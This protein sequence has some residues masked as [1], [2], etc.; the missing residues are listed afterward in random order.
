[1]TAR[2]RDLRGR[3]LAGKYVLAERIGSGATGIVFRAEQ[4]SLDRMV[5]VKLLRRDLAADPERARRFH[6]EAC[7]ASRLHHANVA[8]VIDYGSDHGRPFLVMELVEGPTL[9]ELAA[10]PGGVPVVRAIDLTRQ[11]CAAL[12]E[13]HGHGVIHGDVKCDNALVEARVDGGDTV[14]VVDF[15]LARVIGSDHPRRAG[16]GTP[17]YLSPERIEGAP[18]GPSGDLYAAGIVLYELLTGAPPFDGSNLD[19]VLRAHL[20]C[21]VIPPSLRR[22]TAAIPRALDELV[23]R[24]LA[25]APRDRFGDAHEL[26]D[27]LATIALPDDPRGVGDHGAIVGGRLDGPTIDW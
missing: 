27:A 21:P 8:A 1:M 15:G 14:K 24:A 2:R 6:E 12:A 26:A 9:G 5:A 23:I 4:R 25:K 18:P 11:L 10:A 22:P 13:A 20:G 7:A 17:A 3:V 19:D 16:G